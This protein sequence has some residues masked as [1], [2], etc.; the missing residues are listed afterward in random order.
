[1]FR[2]V[3]FLGLIL[4]FVLVVGAP[5]A[6]AAGRRE[7]EGLS[8]RG[9]LTALWEAVAKRIPIPGLEG[10]SLSDTDPDGNPGDP[11]SGPGMDPNGKPT[12]P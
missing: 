8:V 6:S 3:R 4:V 10:I 9:V 12:G 2:T 11:N 7:P 5:P 1:M